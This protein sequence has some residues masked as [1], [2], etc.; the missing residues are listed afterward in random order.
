M[1]W[2]KKNLDMVN[3]LT[4]R[5]AGSPTVFLWGDYREKEDIRIYSRSTD[6]ETQEA[7][8][9]LIDC[10][11]KIVAS[12]QAGNEDVELF[13]KAF[14][15]KTKPVWEKAGEKAV[16]FSH[17]FA[18]FAVLLDELAHN[19]RAAI[20]LRVIQSLW[21]E[22]PPQE[23]AYQILTA[24]LNDTNR[25]NREFA[26]DRI[27]NFNLRDFLPVLN[28]MTGTEADMDIKKRLQQAIDL[29]TQGYY[30]DEYDNERVTVIFRHDKG[31][32][33]FFIKKDG[34]TE[35]LIKKE[36]DTRLSQV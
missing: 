36:I 10:I 6:S 11:Y 2:K 27:I 24:G 20:R 28:T 15:S 31:R 1:N 9:A 16:Q 7:Y 29:L 17:Y 12:N 18:P 34:L 22:L 32:T 4:L 33:G 25:K 8:S 26:I 19:R 23:L 13:R 30:V 3:P 14:F 5:K 35:I 21:K